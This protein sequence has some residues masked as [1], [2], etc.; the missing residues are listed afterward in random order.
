MHG[1]EDCIWGFGGESQNKTDPLEDLDVHG[2]IILKQI[3][4]K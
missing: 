3:L 4:Y 1:D 2:R